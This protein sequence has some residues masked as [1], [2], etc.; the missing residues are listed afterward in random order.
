LL[1]AAREDGFDYVTTN[2]PQTLEPRTD[3]TAL[4]SRWWRTSVVGRMDVLGSTEWATHMSI[5]A[6][7][8]PEIPSPEQDFCQKVA[9]MAL[10]ASASQLWIRTPLTEQG[11]AAFCSLHRYCDG[12]PNVGMM[13]VLAEGQQNQNPAAVICQQI[14]LMHKAIGA[15]LKAICLPTSIFLTNKRGY[16]ALSKTHQVLIT[17]VLRR[18]GR[19]LRFLV[20][21]PSRH[22]EITGIGK[23][24]CLPYLQYILHLRKR[25][26]IAQI[27]DSQQSSLEENYLD[28]LQRPLQPL[29]D[30]LEF[31]T[32]E[33]FEKDPIKYA[34]YQK[35]IL[36]ALQ[37]RCNTDSSSPLVLL[38]VGAGRGPLVRAA[39][40]ALQELG[41][42]SV[43][44]HIYAI[45]KNP[46][47]I[48]FLESMARHDVTWKDKVTVIHSDM[49]M[50]A[51][52]QI[53]QADFCISEL[54]GSFGDNELSPECLDGLVPTA[55]WTDTTIS[56]P[57]QYSAYLAPIF[58]QRLHSE[59]RAQSFFPNLGEGGL[60]SAPMGSL[61][62]M[63]TPY[64][65][66]MHA[67]SQT[68]VEQLC[69]TFSHPTALPDKERTAHLQF[70]PNPTHGTGCGSGYGP[71][72]PAVAAIA[73]SVTLEQGSITVH[74]FVGT[75][76]AILY[77]DVIISTRPKNFS[78]G[79]FSW[80]PIYFPLREPLHVP[81][82]ATL[83]A[84][85]WR[86]TETQGDNS[87]R[88]WYEWCG[89][90]TDPSGTILGQSAI[91]NPN[92]RSCHVAL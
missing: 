49:R 73:Q 91:H 92:G 22:K 68:H 19:T 33:T 81:G 10:Q 3:V 26:E 8:L 32:Y 39:L 7:L 43:P 51:T 72:D 84:S 45:E 78:V 83:T 12:A 17:E 61:K 52:F 46:S 80:F 30:Q 77:D 55:F 24:K 34:Q 64:V 15:Q 79:M 6:V 1:Q 59:A 35:A 85:V 14:V 66:R 21:G 44:F 41:N 53:P 82:G 42:L 87:G 31:Q 37:D 74:G 4:E 13:L 56:I 76:D 16:P 9:S 62:A 48:I 89:K 90:V 58:S 2:L 20:E 71:Y 54:L 40:A 60:D 75:F 67:A 47:A 50:L 70:T 27:L 23:T 65:V 11:I 57:A 69:W 28:Q 63:E 36:R 18:I 38:V 86:R 5:P 29:A 25:P 88:V